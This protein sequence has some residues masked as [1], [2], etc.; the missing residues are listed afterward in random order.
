VHTHGPHCG[1]DHAHDEPG[2]PARS[3]EPAG[4]P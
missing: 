2:R 3:P 1:H 4:K